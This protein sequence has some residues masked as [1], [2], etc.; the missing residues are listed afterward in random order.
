[1]A[2]QG[3]LPIFFHSGLLGPGREHREVRK[4]TEITRPPKGSQ[5]LGFSD[6]CGQQEENK[7]ET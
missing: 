2:K 7:L 5:M 4:G 1:M 6:L 3:L